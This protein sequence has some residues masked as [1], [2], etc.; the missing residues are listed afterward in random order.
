MD[1][2]VRKRPGWQNTANFRSVTLQV[3]I[4]CSFYQ[5]FLCVESFR[6]IRSFKHKVFSQYISVM[7]RPSTSRG[8]ESDEE[9]QEQA[10]SFA[11][12]SWKGNPSRLA[13]GSVISAADSNT[14]STVV[15]V[16][17]LRRPEAIAEIPVL[18]EEQKL[19]AMLGFKDEDANKVGLLICSTCTSCFRG[20]WFSL[21]LQKSIFLREDF[22]GACGVQHSNPAVT[23]FPHH[24]QLDTCD[25][26]FAIPALTIRSRVPNIQNYIYQLLDVYPLCEACLNCLREQSHLRDRY[27][28]VYQETPLEILFATYG[29]LIVVNLH[30]WYS[31][32]LDRFKLRYWPYWIGLFLIAL[33]SYVLAVLVLPLFILTLS[34]HLA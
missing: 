19:R 2:N 34:V 31:I 8:L 17:S 33:C 32:V 28:G 21:C 26:H 23:D 24:K 25:E 4:L 30:P 1:S 5:L 6:N 22:C 12:K 29:A 7:S 27:A 15:S 16:K 10:S 11:T 3:S 20:D 18:S 13:A 14:G 9:S